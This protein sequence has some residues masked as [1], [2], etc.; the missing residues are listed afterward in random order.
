MT[1]RKKG[2]KLK[3]GRPSAY[4]VRFDRI[5]RK[6]ALLGSTD[7]QLADALGVTVPTPTNWKAAHPTFLAALKEGKEHAD[8][9]VVESLYKRAT[10]WSHKA[11]KIVTVALGANQGSE[12]RQIPYI[13]KYP[14][15]ATSMIFWLKNRRREDWR[16]KHDVEHSGSPELIAALDAARGRATGR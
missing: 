8:A 9:A 1:A 5:A 12:V 16:D 11:V 14:P 3:T 13:E 15:D 7:A 10:G 4:D 6:F 2:P